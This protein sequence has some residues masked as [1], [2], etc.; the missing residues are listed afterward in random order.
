MYRTLYLWQ[1][2]CIAAIF[3]FSGAVLVGASVT[4]TIRSGITD[5]SNF[6]DDPAVLMLGMFCALIG[7]GAWVL[8]ATRLSLAVS[9]THSISKT[10]KEGVVPLWP[11]SD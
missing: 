7:A 4:N 5:V 3:E 8:L 1:A 10:H 9:T 11:S 6:A 2:V